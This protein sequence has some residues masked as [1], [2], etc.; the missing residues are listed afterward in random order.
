MDISNNVLQI[1]REYKS[2]L[3]FL[4]ESLRLKKSVRRQKQDQT[5]K[6]AKI[7]AKC[8]KIVLVKILASLAVEKHQPIAGKGFNFVHL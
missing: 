3:S 2:R 4:R 8:A 5:A 1:E 7:Y 6:G